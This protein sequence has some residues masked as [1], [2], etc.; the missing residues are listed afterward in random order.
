MVQKDAYVGDEAQSKCG[1]LELKY[2]VNHGNVIFKQLIVNV[3]LFIW[4]YCLV[5]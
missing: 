1:V 3:Y 2:A 5:K 4:N